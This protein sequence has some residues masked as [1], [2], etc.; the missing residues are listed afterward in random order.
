MDFGIGIQK[1]QA[2]AALMA[3]VGMRE[4]DLEEHFIRA[5][6]HGGQNIN[7]TSTAVYIKHLPSGIEV[8]CQ[9]TRSQPLNRY[10]ARRMIA[11]KLDERISGRLSEEQMRREK[12]RRQKRKRSKRAKNKMLDDKH[13]HAQKKA[14]RSAA[15]YE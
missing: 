4:N 9:T 5:Q 14:G 2:L 15:S 8:K 7:K 11:E 1:A 13:H 3:K 12:I 6:G 10:L